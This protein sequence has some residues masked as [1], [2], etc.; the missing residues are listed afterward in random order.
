MIF[1]SSKIK[2]FKI[3]MRIMMKTTLANCKKPISF[4]NSCP[5]KKSSKWKINNK[6]KKISKYN[7][8]KKKMIS[9]ASLI[10][11]IIKAVTFNKM[12]PNN[13]MMSVILIVNT[14][15]I[16]RMNSLIKIKRRSFKIS[17]KLIKIM[18][19]KLI[20]SHNSLNKIKLSFRTLTAISN[21][22]SNWKLNKTE[23]QLIMMIIIGIKMN[24]SLR[25][26]ISNK[27]NRH[28]KTKILIIS[29]IFNNQNNQRILLNSL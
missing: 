18:I 27:M 12:N 26:L 10:T 29:K 7:K 20:N 5:T 3:L 9:T 2:T 22:I 4:N 16:I 21:S 1:C 19:L 14:S 15:K 23:M 11:L 28:I 13:R 17:S 25:A 24:F 8:A 6:F